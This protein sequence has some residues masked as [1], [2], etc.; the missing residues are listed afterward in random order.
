LRRGDSGRR[1]ARPPLAGLLIAGLCASLTSG[2]G[3]DERLSSAQ[4]S[5]RLGDIE[6]QVRSD[7]DK[8]AGGRGDRTVR[9][10]SLEAFA[11][12]LERSADELRH[13]EPPED[14]EPVV[15]RFADGMDAQAA[16]A[17][18]L[19]RGDQLTVNQILTKLE[20]PAAR[21]RLNDLA[22]AGR[23]LAEQGY[24]PREP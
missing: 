11:R 6:A 19:A 17:R 12:T 21:R 9:D 13:I 18:E 3:D 2:C 1:R 4:F 20:S 23:E 7:F 10:Q 22:S 5:E 16:F 8:V 15:E 14:V 24:L